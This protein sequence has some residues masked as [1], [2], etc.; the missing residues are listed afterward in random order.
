M[1]RYELPL[2]EVE[3]YKQLSSLSSNTFNDLWRLCFD[4]QRI[5]VVLELAMRYSTYPQR[6]P[7]S[8][9]PGLMALLHEQA[10]AYPHPIL[11]YALAMY[12]LKKN[13]VDRA[14]H[15]LMNALNDS[16][17][18]DGSDTMDMRAECAHQL[19]NLHIALKE[20]VAGMVW[21][22]KAIVLGSRQAMT[23]VL[24]GTFLP[25]DSVLPY[26]ERK[27]FS[28][29]LKKLTQ[30]SWA[31]Y[32][33]LYDKQSSCQ[34]LHHI[35]YLFLYLHDVTLPALPHIPTM[36]GKEIY[37]VLKGIVQKDPYIAAHFIDYGLKMG[38][39]RHD[40]PRMVLTRLADLHAIDPDFKRYV[41]KL[42][43]RVNHLY[44]SQ[45]SHILAYG[46]HDEKERVL[47]AMSCGNE[48]KA[49][50]L[51]TDPERRRY[52]VYKLQQSLYWKLH[53]TLHS[54]T[55]PGLLFHGEFAKDFERGGVVEQ[56]RAMHACLTLLE[57]SL[58]D[59]PAE[60][61]LLTQ[62]SSTVFSS[63]PTLTKGQGV[64]LLARA[65]TFFSKEIEKIGEV[66]DERAISSYKRQF[67]E[68]YQ[69]MK[70]SF[71]KSLREVFQETDHILEE[72]GLIR[73]ESPRFGQST[74][75][76]S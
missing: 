67:L 32:Q 47:R 53:D 58:I 49:F 41:N 4:A 22:F 73:I 70:C 76:M 12:A 74:L 11:L 40:A 2:R 65:Y 43:V 16:T 29:F 24:Q 17:I 45:Q 6:I 13:D 66:V 10:K 51:E 62:S 54:Q 33:L 75:T 39:F 8:R 3:Q 21:I 69:R 18:S 34:A 55:S 42:L 28:D 36:D 20:N 68:I 63:R 30:Q 72:S 71:T 27:L 38:A 56:Q 25:A 5:D 52:D 46:T 57:S 37:A 23:H 7:V 60:K 64:R 31:R 35:L 44:W 15:F 19:A 9:V 14:K 26:E 50:I 61:S 48:F 1:F 59:D